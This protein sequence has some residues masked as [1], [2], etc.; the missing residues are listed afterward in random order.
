MLGMRSTSTR[1]QL[2]ANNAQGNRAFLLLA[3]TF[4][5]LVMY[6]ITPLLA[7]VV[8]IA[9]CAMGIRVALYFGWQQTSVS[10]RT[11]NLLA[12]LA[13]ITLSWFGLA[14]GLLNSMIN[15]LVIA[16]ALKLMLLTH[17]RDFL[18][19]FTACLFLIGCALI[20][21]LT[22]GAWLGFTLILIMLFTSLA[23]FYAPS[24]SLRIGLTKSAVLLLQALPITIL[25][26]LTL[27]HLP[28]LWQMPTS[29]SQQTG[30]SEKVTPGDIA[31][32]A[33]S[34][35][36]AFTA[37]FSSTPPPSHKRYWRAMTLEDFDGKTWAISDKRKKAETQ[38]LKM[39][40][41]F[42]ITQPSRPLSY[43]LIIEPSNQKWL[44]SLDVSTQDITEA[45]PSIT[46]QFDY[47]LRT[48]FP[49]ASKR[50]FYLTYYP[51]E[52]TYSPLIGFDEQVNL[53][54]PDTSNPKT[55][56]W[57]KKLRA[58]LDSDNAV[59]HQILAYFRQQN[60][61]YTLTPNPMPHAPIDTFMFEE[62]AGFCA[63]YASAMAFSL[64]A[65][66][67]PARMVAGY[68]GGET[69]GENVLQVRQYDAHA[70]V[71]ALIDGVWVRFD[72]TAVVA[73]SRINAG[74]QSTLAELRENNTTSLLTD[75]SNSTLFTSLQSWFRQIDYQW[76]RLVLGFDNKTQ[77]DLLK[78]L[79]GTV[80][81]QKMT[82]LFLGLLGGV[83]ILLLAYFYPK[84]TKRN[85]PKYYKYYLDA[86]KHVSKLT[87]IDRKQLGASA[88]YHKIA[89]YL[90]PLAKQ[91]FLLITQQFEAAH[92][93]QPPHGNDKP[94]PSP[95]RKHNTNN[96]P[97][98]NMKR[99]L[100]KLKKA[101]KLNTP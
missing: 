97:T 9:V 95:Y 10:S 62:M 15:L 18:Q 77:Y 55:Q 20:F 63:H 67:I 38:L 39:R 17:S 11:V 69:L 42:E 45:G 98:E 59:A 4:I 53:A 32:L 35:A 61:T 24:Q 3:I 40:K 96:A 91:Q 7:W 46:R 28:P 71:E 54:Y 33:Q 31:S 57:V 84:H 60:F 1:R 58:Q 43:Q 81:S 83:S 73:P 75:F 80:T 93:Q 47:S 66:G 79:L 19:L 85:T 34:S 89:P 21:S 90:S 6:L 23:L 41:Q 16:C 70:W 68:Q 52:R 44:F 94:R 22:I 48:N 99:A 12:I 14:I 26:F 92:Y 2:V 78:K 74:F 5:A 29:K 101:Q 64:R 88:Y 30:L 36:L 49:I 100:V 76:S 8:I 51:N 56:A 27:P 50:A 87:K 82:L 25:L 13:I 37:T 72:P 86:V 65:A